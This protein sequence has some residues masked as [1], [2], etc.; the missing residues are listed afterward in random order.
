MALLKFTQKK[1]KI[2]QKKVYALYFKTEK[3]QKIV[4]GLLNGFVFPGPTKTSSCP[5]TSRKY[6][7]LYQRKQN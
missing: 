5:P 7:R 2:S 1:L 3:D 4:W 6:T